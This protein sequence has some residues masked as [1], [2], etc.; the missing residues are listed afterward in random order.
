MKLRKKHTNDIS[1]SRACAIA[2][3]HL[4]YAQNYIGKGMLLGH[5]YCYSLLIGCAIAHE[6][7]LDRWKM[8]E[9]KIT[10]KIDK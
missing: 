5:E 1:P 8:T 3:G 4:R 2:H 9:M 10:K 7:G 6:N